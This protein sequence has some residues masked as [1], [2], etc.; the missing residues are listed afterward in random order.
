MLDQCQGKDVCF[1]A[2]DANIEVNRP[3]PTARFQY[4]ER[5]DVY[6]TYNTKYV[7]KVAIE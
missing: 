2:T 6:I 4:N 3:S 7:A 5:E 1:H